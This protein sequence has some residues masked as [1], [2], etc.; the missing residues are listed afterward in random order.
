MIKHFRAWILSKLTDAERT[1]FAATVFVHPGFCDTGTMGKDTTQVTQ[2]TTQATK[3]ESIEERILSAIRTNTRISQKQISE[4]I[5]IQV[6]SVKYYVR[7]MKKEQ[8]IKR[9]GTSQKGEWIILK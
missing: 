3:S 4:Q 2:G 9:V 1:S 6:D 5:D 8:I 7:K